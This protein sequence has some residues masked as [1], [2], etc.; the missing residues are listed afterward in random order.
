MT[1]STGETAVPFIP[2]WVRG[3][4]ERRA[5]EPRAR[6]STPNPGFSNA[7]TVVDFLESEVCL[8]TPG[9]VGKRQRS[10][11]Q[12]GDATDDEPVRKGANPMTDRPF[13]TPEYPS[14]AASDPLSDPIVDSHTTS[15]FAEAQVAASP[16]ETGSSMGNGSAAGN[17]STTESARV[18]AATAKDEARSVAADAKQGTRQVADT[19]KAEARDVAAQTQ[20][21]A[22]ELF[23]QLRSEATDQASGQAQRAAGGLRTLASELGEMADGGQHHGVA[24]DVARQASDR[25]RGFADWLE[26]REP[27]DILNE[28][29][30]FA[31]RKPGTFLVAAAAL[32]I[33]G[34]RLTRGLADDDSTQGSGASPQSFGSATPTYGGEPYAAEGADRYAAT[35]P[36]AFDPDRVGAGMDP[37]T[38]SHPDPSHRPVDSGHGFPSGGN[39]REIR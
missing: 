29:R 16:H 13:T 12:R 20:Q 9:W 34:G 10:L 17:G 2:L 19:A 6:A 28:A 3:P 35:T 15:T 4:H 36:G 26:Q 38:Y 7:S 31:R 21:Q 25:A 39:G 30:D 32:G 1:S 22:R 24:S 8:T 33:L 14:T 27:G 23:N 11:Q 5:A 37:A 18:A